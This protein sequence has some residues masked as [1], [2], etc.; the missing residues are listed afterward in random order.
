MVT[1]HELFVAD[2][3]REVLLARVG[4]GVPCEF[5]GTGESFSTAVPVAWK[6]SF[7]CKMIIFNKNNY[8]VVKNKNRSVN[9][10]QVYKRDFTSVLHTIVPNTFSIKYERT[11]SQS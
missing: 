1:S 6:W 3:T 9:E 8:Y 10:Q 5:V 2:G 7:T 11:L 4:P